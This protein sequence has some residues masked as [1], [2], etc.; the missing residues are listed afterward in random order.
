VLTIGNRLI[1][2]VDFEDVLA[3]ISLFCGIRKEVVEP[4]GVDVCSVGGRNNHKKME[5]AK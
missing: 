5:V 4:Q 3:S 2:K 1:L